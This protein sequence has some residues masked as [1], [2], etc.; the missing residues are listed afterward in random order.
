MPI[1]ERMARTTW[2]IYLGGEVTMAWMRKRFGISTMTASRD[3]NAIVKALPVGQTG[4]GMGGLRR[5]GMVRRIKL[6]K[7]EVRHLFD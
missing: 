6:S 2:R 5:K 3:M 4:A 7:R 1:A